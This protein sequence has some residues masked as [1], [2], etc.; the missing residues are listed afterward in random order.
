VLFHVLKEDDLSVLSADV[1]GCPHEENV[2]SAGCLP[3]QLSRLGS[4]LHV[5]RQRA[6]PVESIIRQHIFN[7]IGST[8][9]NLSGEVKLGL[10]ILKQSV[11]Y[12]VH[13]KLFLA[14]LSSLV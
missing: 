11:N 5:L 2:A 7:L 4:L 6:D 3:L 10:D 12:E 8:D 13:N 9:L 14:G 1:L